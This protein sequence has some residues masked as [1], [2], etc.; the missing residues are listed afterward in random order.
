MHAYVYVHIYI[1][2]YAYIDIH[3]CIYTQIHLFLNIYIKT[4][5]GSAVV[6]C[7]GADCVVLGVEK[8]ATASLQ[9]SR[10]IR[11]IAK[12]D[13]HLTIA[14]AGFTADAR[15]LIE[16]VYICIYIYTFIWIYI[17]IYIYIYVYCIYIFICIYTYIYT[18]V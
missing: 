2:L 10:T 17:Y 12:L 9:E 5:T 18:F 8:K 15:V 6:G 16:K 14:F 11:K 3:I 7:I 13:D 4:R 1:Y